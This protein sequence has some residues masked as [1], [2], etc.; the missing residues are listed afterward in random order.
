MRAETSVNRSRRAA[1]A[2]RPAVSLKERMAGHKFT[3]HVD[4]LTRTLAPESRHIVASFSSS[5][6]SRAV[7]LIL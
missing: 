2:G 4:A 7:V 5:T 3:E 6:T 1:K